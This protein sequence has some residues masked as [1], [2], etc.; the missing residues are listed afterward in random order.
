[1]TQRVRLGD[2]IEVVFAPATRG[3]QTA[4]LINGRRAFAV[5]SGSLPQIGDRW[6]VMVVGMN[7]SHTYYFVEPLNLVDAADGL[8][9]ELIPYVPFYHEYIR[10]AEAWL[11]GL[12]PSIAEA[13]EEDEDLA[14]ALD[15]ILSAQPLPDAYKE[16]VYK[17]FN[18]Q[19]PAQVADLAALSSE[20]EGGI[21]A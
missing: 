20:V 3:V 1:M 4:T 2:R 21:Y 18:L 9:E 6:E 17:R 15:D 7:R 13:G 14:E 8:N 11:S 16:A 12:L 5:D 10:V 19:P